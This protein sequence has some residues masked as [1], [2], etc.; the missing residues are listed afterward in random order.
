MVVVVVLVVLSVAGSKVDVVCVVVGLLMG[1]GSGLG[2]GAGPVELEE[3]GTTGRVPLDVL[4]TVGVFGASPRGLPGLVVVVVVG[5]GAG[6]CVVR[7]YGDLTGGG[8]TVSTP[9]GVE[10]SSTP[11]DVS[12]SIELGDGWR[13]VI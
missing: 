6:Y 1:T 3:P 13:G 11:F 9:D 4:V 7:T 2:D 12:C 8:V 5:A 10:A